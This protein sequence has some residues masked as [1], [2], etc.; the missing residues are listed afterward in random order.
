[1]KK[2]IV[3][4]GNFVNASINRPELCVKTQLVPRSKHTPYL[5]RY[6][7]EYFPDI[8]TFATHPTKQCK[9]FPTNHNIFTKEA[10]AQAEIAAAVRVFARPTAGQ[11]SACIR[12][13]HAGCLVRK[14]NAKR[15]LILQVLSHLSL[16]KSLH[17]DLG[18]R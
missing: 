10:A 12:L 9:C 1:M 13:R 2:L 8:Y 6:T 5:L 14:T 4:F 7:H 18:R 16:R 17:Q 3:A 15:A 11:K